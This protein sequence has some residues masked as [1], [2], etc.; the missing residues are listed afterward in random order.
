MSYDITLCDPVTH[1]I[2]VF[3]YLHQMHGVTYVMDGTSAAWLNIKYNYS[4]WYDRPG[5]FTE[6]NKNKKGIYSIDGISGAES[7]PILKKAIAF[8]GTWTEEFVDEEHGIFGYCIPTRENAI[9][10]LEQ[11]LVMARLRPDG[12]W[13]V[14]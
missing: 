4:W 7:I 2:L 5:V 12:I 10:P 11:L 6:S 13:K 1:D 3:D 8:L 9:G 14:D